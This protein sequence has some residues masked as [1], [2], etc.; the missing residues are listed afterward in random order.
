MNLNPTQRLRAKRKEVKRTIYLSTCGIFHKEYRA[1]ILNY[2]II[3]AMF[4]IQR[5]LPV[6]KII[7][8]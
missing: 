2:L 8:R 5:I 3:N 6:S 1:S 4:F 7:P